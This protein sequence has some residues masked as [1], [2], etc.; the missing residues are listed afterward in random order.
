[1]PSATK[2]PLKY[3]FTV[4]YQDGTG[5]RQTLEDVS[6]SIPGGSAYSDVRIDEVKYF[7]IYEPLREVYTVDLE[8][9][10]FIVGDGTLFYVGDEGP[11]PYKLIFWRQHRHDF[12]VGLD[13]ISHTVKYIIGYSDADGKEHTIT[14]E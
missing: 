2:V 8:R 5:F 3:L 10:C 14:I 6:E 4:T 7:S 9:G 13:E 1:M 12:S 11:K